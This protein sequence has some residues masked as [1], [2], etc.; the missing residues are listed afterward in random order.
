MQLEHTSNLKYLNELRI[1][2]WNDVIK[3]T[4][5]TRTLYPNDPFIVDYLAF[6]NEHYNVDICRFLS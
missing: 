4:K 5:W 2:N 1:L 6:P 3:V